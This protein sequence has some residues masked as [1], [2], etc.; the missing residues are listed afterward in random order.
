M[1]AP[2][3]EQGRPP[4]PTLIV[5]PKAELARL[6]EADDF[7]ASGAGRVVWLLVLFTMVFFV[8]AW[9][10]N[11]D[12]VSTG[13]GKVIPSSREQQ[14]ESLEGGILAQLDVHVG[15]IVDKGQVLARLDPTR[16]ESSVGETAAR[17]R[18]STRMNSSH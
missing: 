12:E 10:F 9:N 16:G 4:V 13:S 3:S 11:I 2:V 7:H 18:K 8:W 17:D 14:I 6:D 1:T 15:D 5:A